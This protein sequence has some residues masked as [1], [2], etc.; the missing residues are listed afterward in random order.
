MYPQIPAMESRERRV[1]LRLNRANPRRAE[2]SRIFAIAKWL[3][4]RYALPG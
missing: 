4:P 1:I 2:F 3:M